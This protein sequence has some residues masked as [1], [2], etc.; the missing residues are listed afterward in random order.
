MATVVIRLWLVGSHYR[1]LRLIKFI[2]QRWL[3]IPIFSDCRR[4]TRTSSNFKIIATETESPS[5][6]LAWCWFI[7]FWFTRL[8]ASL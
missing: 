6:N 1:L 2:H 5:I 4:L 7:R 8:G 3:S